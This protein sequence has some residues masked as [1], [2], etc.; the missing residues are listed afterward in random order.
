[1]NNRHE[2]Y[3]FNCVFNVLSSS[4]LYFNKKMSDS[5]IVDTMGM[6]SSGCSSLDKLDILS[7]NVPVDMGFLEN[8]NSI[9]NHIHN[10]ASTSEKECPLTHKN[11]MEKSFEQ[12]H[13]QNYCLSE[14]PIWV[15]RCP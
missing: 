13:Q 10:K 7:L 6:P 8:Y 15:K 1:M 12:S 3:T 14:T 11:S 9:R 2:F 5:V 4:K